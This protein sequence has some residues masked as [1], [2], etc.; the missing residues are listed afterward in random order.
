MAAHAGRSNKK[1]THAR[2]VDR[3]EN[4]DEDGKRSRYQCTYVWR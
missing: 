2:A 3:P 4:F 1:R